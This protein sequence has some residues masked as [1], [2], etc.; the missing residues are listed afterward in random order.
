M[1]KQT[2]VRCALLMFLAYYPVTF[3]QQTAQF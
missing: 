2:E 3:A 1:K